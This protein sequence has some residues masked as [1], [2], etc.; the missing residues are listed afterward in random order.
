[1]SEGFCERDADSV[2]VGLGSPIMCDDAVGLRISEEIEK[3]SI[4]ARR[5]SEASTSCLS[6]TDT[7]M[8]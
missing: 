3:M 7:S 1:M 8:R 4:P 2:V 5:P 6:S